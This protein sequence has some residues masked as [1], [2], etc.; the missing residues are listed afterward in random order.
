MSD[1]LDKMMDYCYNENDK[2]T[3]IEIIIRTRTINYISGWCLGK[4]PEIKPN[5]IILSESIREVQLMLYLPFLCTDPCR[6]NKPLKWRMGRAT[7]RRSN[8]PYSIF[9][10]PANR[11][12]TASVCICRTSPLYDTATLSCADGHIFILE[13]CSLTIGKNT[14]HPYTGNC[15]TWWAA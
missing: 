15:N 4:N 6:G 10:H 13:W 5:R 2:D 9:C 11:L 14:G 8:L 7:S 1:G 12:L 3:P